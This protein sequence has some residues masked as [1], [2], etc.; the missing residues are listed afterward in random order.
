MRLILSLA[1]GLA[2]LTGAALASEITPAEDQILPYSAAMPACHD[3]AVLEKITSQFVERESRFWQSSLV[4]AGYEKIRPISF[5]PWGL[6]LIPR[7]FCTAIAVVSDGKKR[8]I[9]YSVREDLGTIGMTF[10][11]EWCIAGLDR[12]LAYSPHCRMARQ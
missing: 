10:G 3:P 2:A 8:R 7:R 9:D 1:F 6:D 4:I 11:V 5:R 12:N